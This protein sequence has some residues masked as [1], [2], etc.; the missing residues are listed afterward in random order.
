MTPT[1][2]AQDYEGLRASVLG[3]APVRGPE[4]G[5]VCH[6]GLMTWLKQPPPKP[7]APPCGSSHGTSRA[8]PVLPTELTRV[9]A[10]IVV[11]LAL[12]AGHG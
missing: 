4:I 10:G 5:T 6:L 9:I 8:E 3:S 11:A 12:E 2:T 1:R 7:I